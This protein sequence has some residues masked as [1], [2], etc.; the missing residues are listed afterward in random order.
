MLF[1]TYDILVNGVRQISG[2][3]L[4]KFAVFVLFCFKQTNKETKKQRKQTKKNIVT[5]IKPN[6]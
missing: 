1:I 4:L 3:F 5:T 2:D 6:T